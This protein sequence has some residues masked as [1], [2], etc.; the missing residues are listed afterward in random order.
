MT[1]ELKGRLDPR[2]HFFL[3]L[4]NLFLHL[5]LGEV[6]DWQSLV[7]I[8]CN[9]SICSLTFFIEQSIVVLIEIATAMILH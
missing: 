6:Y 2:C 1:E 8:K 5:E 3:N 7:T 4:E 9:P